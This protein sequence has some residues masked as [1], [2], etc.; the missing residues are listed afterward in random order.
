M[1]LKPNAFK[2]ALAAGRTQIGLWCSLASPIAAEILGDAGFDWILIDGEH[3]PN[4]PYLVMQ[5]LQAAQAGTAAAVA[6]VAWNDPVLIKRMLDVGVMSVLVPYVQDE[7]EAARAVAAV[8][9]PPRGVRGVAT[10]NRATRYGRIQDYARK[11]DGE[12]CV[13]V[14]AET[15]QA[16]ARIEAMGGIDGLDGIFIGPADLAASMGHLGDPRHPAVRRAIDDAIGRIRATGKAAGILT[17]HVED[18]K[19][20]IA[21]GANFVAVGSDAGILVG[22]TAA[23]VK[24]FKG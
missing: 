5:Q 22:A 16:L 10:N 19:A 3:A 7:H 8:R 15:A 14:Q 1:E 11:A 24:T 12:I 21:A 4:D 20:F 2:R 13:L 23:L 18:A 9:Y 6:R 17:G